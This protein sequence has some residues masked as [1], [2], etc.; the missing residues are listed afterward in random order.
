MKLTQD[1]VQYL[2][3]YVDGILY[4]KNS[5]NPKRVPNGSLAGKPNMDGY[6][7]TQINKKKHGNH[8]IIF[9]MFNGYLP[10]Q[11]DHKDNNINN[12]FINN[13]R[14]ATCA[15]NQANSKTRKDNTSGFKGVKFSKKTNKY[16]VSI[17]KN[18]KRYYFGQYI[19]LEEAALVA[20][21][22]RM[23]LHGDFANNG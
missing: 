2:F 19:T 15:Q 23:E 17:Q 3:E 6:L 10:E 11:V 14:A 16:E 1:Y 21:Q 22:K 5:T 8:R 9:L 7:E 20:K 18:N 12:N 4:W 13:L